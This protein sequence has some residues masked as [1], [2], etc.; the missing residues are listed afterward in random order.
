M[1]S[2]NSGHY[3]Q[4]NAHI[5]Q[6]PTSKPE[7]WL[8]KT[9][10]IRTPKGLGPFAVSREKQGLRP[11]QVRQSQGITINPGR[12]RCYRVGGPED[13]ARRVGGRLLQSRNVLS[14]KGR[15]EGAEEVSGGARG[16]E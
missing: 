7:G 1:G 16:V 14:R 13:K 11:K 9:S 5:A 15:H 4:A 10:W 3:R 12:R 8:P 6:F 2:R